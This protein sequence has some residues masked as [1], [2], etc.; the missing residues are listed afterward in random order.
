MSSNS[1]QAKSNKVAIALSAIFPGIGQFY[2]GD[3]PKGLVFFIASIF[4]DAILLPEGYWG[5]V[6]GEIDFNVNL[7][8]RLVLLA[9]FRMWVVIDADRSVTRKNAEILAAMSNSE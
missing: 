7:Y 1:A 9:S 6:R 8:I 5:I 4:L 3:L 2:N